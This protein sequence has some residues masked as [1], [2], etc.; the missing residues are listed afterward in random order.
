M[1]VCVPS[2]AGDRRGDV[3]VADPG[4]VQGLLVHRLVS[5]RGVRWKY[6]TLR[7]IPRDRRAAVY[8]W[9]WTAMEAG[10]AI[11]SSST[12]VKAC[13]EKIFWREESSSDEWMI[14]VWEI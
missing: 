7:S 2:G 3:V 14:T 11:W 12:R 6:A 4:F 13:E 8:R 5:L 1:C 9:R 10:K